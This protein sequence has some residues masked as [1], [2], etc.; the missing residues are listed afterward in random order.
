MNPV[1][2]H[3]DKQENCTRVNKLRKTR[4]EKMK[5]DTY[6]IKNHV[7]ERKELLFLGLS[8]ENVE[9]I[10]I[11]KDAIKGLFLEGYD[12]G[13]VYTQDMMVPFEK[14]NHVMVLFNKNLFDLEQLN[15]SHMHDQDNSQAVN[16]HLLIHKDITSITLYYTDDTQDQYTVYVP[17]HID[18]MYS[19]NPCQSFIET[20][21]EYRL[22]IKAEKSQQ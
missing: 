10:Y 14:Y 16:D 1:S 6:P 4:L 18:L 13:H 12:Q 9:G 5:K 19:S 21:K 8:F 11:S 7:S 17:E 2:N 3:N 15:F 22:V 20:E